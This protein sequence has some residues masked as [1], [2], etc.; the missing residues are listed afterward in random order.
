MSTDFVLMAGLSIMSTRPSCD[1]LIMSRNR[2]SMG[3][4]LSSLSRAIMSPRAGLYSEASA[5]PTVRASLWGRERGMCSC[6]WTW[7]PA[8]DEAEVVSARRPPLCIPRRQR[9]DAADMV[10]YE[11]A[12]LT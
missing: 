10:E 12:R 6:R 11:E 1:E 9:S 3:S 8:D 4:P 5:D 2:G 7:W